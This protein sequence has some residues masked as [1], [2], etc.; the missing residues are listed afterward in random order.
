MISR[1]ISYVIII[2]VFNTD[3]NKKWV[4]SVPYDSYFMTLYRVSQKNV[5]INAPNQMGAGH[6]SIRSAAFGNVVAMDCLSGEEFYK[7]NDSVFVA[8][9]KFSSKHESSF[10]CFFHKKICA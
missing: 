9:K 10:K 8:R 2:F 5:Y 3:R 4:F 1:H 7:S 6:L